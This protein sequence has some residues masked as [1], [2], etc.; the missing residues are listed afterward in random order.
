VVKFNSLG[1]NHDEIIDFA[2]SNL[3]KHNVNL[4]LTNSEWR[5]AISYSM[6]ILK[7]L[8]TDD[9]DYNVC[10]QTH[11]QEFNTNNNT[12]NTTPKR[13]RVTKTSKLSVQ[14]ISQN[15]YIL[16]CAELELEALSRKY[17]YE[18]FK[19]RYVIENHPDKLQEYKEKEEEKMKKKKK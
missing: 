9:L 12:N 2:K 16:S 15:K 18:A 8:A 3:Q 10:L 19:L 17:E 1:R 6:N 5:E 13:K 11:D 7:K 4:K 14:K